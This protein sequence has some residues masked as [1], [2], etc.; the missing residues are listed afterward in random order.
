MIV[1]RIPIK[2]DEFDS[3]LTPEQKE[4]AQLAKDYLRIALM[5]ESATK[6]VATKLDILNDEFQALHSRN[7]IHS[8]QCRVKAPGS[9]AE[10]LRR[11]GLPVEIQ[12]AQDNLYDLAGVRVICSYIE[13]IYTIAS[14]L[15]QQDDIH[16]VRQRD[17]IQ[18]PKENGYHSLHLIIT[19]PVFFSDKKRYVPVEIQI[20]TVAMDFW[21]TLEHDIHYKSKGVV[22][23]E[24]VRELTACADVINQTDIRM[25]E[26][27]HKTLADKEQSDE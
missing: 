16:L 6:E 21:A 13:D 25:Q 17:Y 1:Q 20:R 12:S 3:A 7:P 22:S 8:I 24:V 14:M 26:L 15:C 19:V 18:N 5:Y 4:L 11:K 10:K 27:Y 23:D 2:F 9:V